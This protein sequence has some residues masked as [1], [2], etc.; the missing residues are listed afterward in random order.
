MAFMR[1]T[2]REVTNDNSR[3]LAGLK[4]AHGQRRFVASNA[5]S[6]REALDE[7]DSTFARGIY[8]GDTPV[9]FAMYGRDSETGRW[10]IIRLMVALEHQRRGYG[11]AAMLALVDILNANPDCAEVF[12]SFVPDNAA[13]RALYSSLGFEDTG[14]IEDGEV[15]YRLRLRRDETP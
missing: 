6:M 13:A 7:P 8:D 14:R 1:I 3:A 15:V 4:V 10:W 12:L 5:Y 9:G 11:R 2:L